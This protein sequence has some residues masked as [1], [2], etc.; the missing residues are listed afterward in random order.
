MSQLGPVFPLTSVCLSLFLSLSLFHTSRTSFPVPFPHPLRHGVDTSWW[1]VAFFCMSLSLCLSIRE[2]LL[3]RAKRIDGSS[4]L[5]WCFFVKFDANLSSENLVETWSSLKNFVTISRFHDDA[6]HFPQ[7]AIRYHIRP[8]GVWVE[9]GVDF[10]RS[11]LYE[12][13]CVWTFSLRVFEEQLYLLILLH[14][15]RNCISVRARRKDSHYGPHHCLHW[16][17]LIRRV[18]SRWH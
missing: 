12:C 14:L 16:G 10:T 7:S 9:G 13:V 11:C 4:W 15:V 8:K 3:K 17:R 6:F 2:T 5:S 1:W 18:S